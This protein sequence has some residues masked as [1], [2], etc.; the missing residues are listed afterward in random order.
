MLHAQYSTLQY[1]TACTVHFT[2]L[3][4]QRCISR[5]SQTLLSTLSWLRLTPHWQ[6][7]R[8]Y[9]QQQG[10]THWDDRGFFYIFYCA[11][12]FCPS[13]CPSCQYKCVLKR[14]LISHISDLTEVQTLCH[15]FSQVL[16]E[17]QS[18]PFHSQAILEASSSGIHL[19]VC[20]VRGRPPPRRLTQMLLHLKIHETGH[21]A[22]LFLITDH[23]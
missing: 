1:I 8:L 6:E 4:P 21:Q 20:N 12:D 17:C 2:E 13:H 7:Q 3:H 16:L 18:S 19:T 15:T 22:L 23:G 9:D 14:C 11:I 10:C 5:V